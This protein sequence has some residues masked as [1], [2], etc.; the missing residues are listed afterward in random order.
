[1]RQI[2]LFKLFVVALLGFVLIGGLAVAD[3]PAAAAEFAVSVSNDSAEPDFPDSITFNLSAESVSPTESVELLYSI[4]EEETLHMSTPAFTP[5]TS[6]QITDSIDMR[7]NQVP[8][9]VDITYHW[10]LIGD[11]GSTYETQ[12]TSM[13]WKD[14]RFD[15]QVVSNDHVSVYAYNG[16]EK[17]NRSILD[18]A[19]RTIDKVQKEFGVE[20]DTPIRIWAYQSQ[21]DFQGALFAN[22][23]EWSVGATFPQLNLIV[24]TLPEGD[25]YSVGRVVPHE[26]THQILYQATKNPFNSPPRWL[27][28]GLA[29]LHQEQG[30]DEY[31]DYVDAAVKKGRLY[32]VRALNSDFPYD[33]NDVHLAYAESLNIVQFIIDH[34]GAAKMS[35]LI[36]AYRQ[37]LSHDEAAMQALGVDLDGLDK[38]WKES[39]GYKGDRGTAGF[40]Q[41]DDVG[42]NNSL[43][44]ALAYGSG[45]IAL[46]VVGSLAI[47][48]L[49]NHRS[50]RKAADRI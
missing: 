19:Q 2:G 38:L 26:V 41:P 12:P 36:A 31:A 46:A 14:D 16:N 21:K 33:P 10:K 3:R 50:N 1:M 49:V 9:G 18:S 11:D 24:A 4:A 22:S 48:F 32:S 43:A 28:E 13:L 47:V 29:V 42:P 30:Q 20:L 34:F 7:I 23:E 17:F 5:G 45:V 15:W 27:D 39:L 44:A 40:V 35:A 37:G 25:D 8:P 6:V